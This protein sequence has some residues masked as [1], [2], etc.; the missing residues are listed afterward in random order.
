M[1]TT[2]DLEDPFAP[3]RPVIDDMP[4]E[5]LDQHTQ[6]L[7]A[8]NSPLLRALGRSLVLVRRQQN[9]ASAVLEYEL[10]RATPEEVAAI[11]AT[12]PPPPP[13]VGVERHFDPDSE[14]FRDL[15]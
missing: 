15:R 5:S 13:P 8:A 4:P 14:A 9:L 10:G 7:L 2:S 1:I 6:A 11:E 12:L 3:L